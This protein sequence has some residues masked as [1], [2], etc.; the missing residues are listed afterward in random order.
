MLLVPGDN[1]NI[2]DVARR[3][4]SVPG[5]GIMRKTQYPYPVFQHGI[6]DLYLIT[7]KHKKSP[8]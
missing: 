5:C 1:I 3:P 2:I 4:L 6:N 7:R 8:K